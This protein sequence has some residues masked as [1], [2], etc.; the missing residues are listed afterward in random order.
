MIVPDNIV[1]LGITSAIGLQAWQLR[2]IIGMKTAIALL[3]IQVPKINAGKKVLS[4][5]F[6]LALPLLFIGCA[7]FAQTNPPTTPGHVQGAPVPAAP[8]VTGT[9]LLMILNA[10]LAFVFPVILGVIRKQSTNRLRIINAL[11]CGVESAARALGDD[12]ATVKLKIADVAI[13]KGVQSELDEH[14]Q[15]ITKD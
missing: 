12:G 13:S 1:Y 10:A 8:G 9:D 5:L 4:V 3:Q 2:E 14:V 6:I 7:A 11:I 15:K